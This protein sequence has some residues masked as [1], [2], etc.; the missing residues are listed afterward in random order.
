[1][2]PKL[3]TDFNH[4]STNPLGTHFCIPA[5]IALAVIR[6]KNDDSLIEKAF[7]RKH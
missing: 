1:M 5:E 2:H 7:L 3:Q 6:M 4:R